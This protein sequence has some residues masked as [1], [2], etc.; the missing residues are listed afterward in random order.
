[1]TSGSNLQP[2]V[3]IK[4][5]GE[6]A[7]II[8]EI[9]GLDSLLAPF[10]I[11]V[12]LCSNQLLSPGQRCSLI[13][14]FSPESAGVYEDSFDVAFPE[15]GINYSIRLSG[16][17]GSS[18]AE[19]DITSSFSSVNFAELDMLFSQDISPYSKKILINNFGDLPLDLYNTTLILIFT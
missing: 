2:E 4:N 9:G 19:A 14:L 1:M 16:E 8:G 15:L 12:D 10:S 13:A 17:G 18:V 5:T 11:V 3:V 6:S 7:I